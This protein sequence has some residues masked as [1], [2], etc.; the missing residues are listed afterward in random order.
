MEQDFALFSSL[1]SGE[2]YKDLKFVV[3]ETTDPALENTNEIVLHA[4]QID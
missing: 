3:L 2:K 4:S 1:L